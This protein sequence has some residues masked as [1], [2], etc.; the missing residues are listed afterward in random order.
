MSNQTNVLGAQLVPCSTSPMTGYQRDGYCSSC[1]GDRGMHTVCALM[2]R[3]FLEF[4][5]SKGNDLITPVPEFGFPGLVPG[6]RWCLCLLRWV[7]ALEAGSAPLVDLE[8]THVSALEFVD[9]DVLRQY[10]ADSED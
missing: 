2:T 5:R 1:A 3:E 4:S 10:S 6:N 9:L 8:A 7:E